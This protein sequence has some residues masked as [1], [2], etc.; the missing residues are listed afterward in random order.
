M[1][2]LNSMTNIKKINIQKPKIINVK[3][4]NVLKVIKKNNKMYKGFGEIYFSSIKYNKIKGWKLHKKMHMTITVPYGLVKFVFNI[5]KGNNFKEVLVGSEKKYYKI[6]SVPS[7]IWFAFKGLSKNDSL[8]CNISNIVHSS[9]E[10]NSC[11]LNEIPYE[12]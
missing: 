3:N 12:W 8:V 1:K 2:K 9:K 10:V 7:N 11:N 4:G 5:N 6:I